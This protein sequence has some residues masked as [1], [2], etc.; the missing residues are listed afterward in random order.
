MGS[1]CYGGMF[2]LGGV[3]EIRV[4]SIMVWGRRRVIFSGAD[5]PCRTCFLPWRVVI[6][7][8]ELG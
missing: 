7:L 2:T 5:I 1:R 4:C 6:L 3:I 8:S